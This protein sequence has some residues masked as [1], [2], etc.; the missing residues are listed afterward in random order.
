MTHSGPT[1]RSSDRSEPAH[2]KRARIPDFPDA[3]YRDA[4]PPAPLRVVAGTRGNASRS[5]R[6]PPLRIEIDPGDVAA[7]AVRLDVAEDVDG[8]PQQALDDRKLQPRPF[9]RCLHP[10]R[11]LVTCLRGASGVAT[12]E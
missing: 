1:P 2:N 10:Q 5:F 8:H 4:S 9:G 3:A 11:K 6:A 7:P 12:G